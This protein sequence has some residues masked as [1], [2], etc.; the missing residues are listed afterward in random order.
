MRV[1]TSATLIT[2]GLLIAGCSSSTPTQPSQ[3]TSAQALSDASNAQPPE[4]GKPEIDPTW[5]NGTTVYMI[6]PHVIQGARES[7]PNLYAQ[8]EELYLVV[9]P[10]PEP[11]DSI[12]QP[13]RYQPQCNP[14][15]HPGLPAAFVF[16]DHIITGAPGFGNHG[17]AG[18]Y[19]APWKIII[20]MYN[21][22]YAKSHGFTP[23]TSAEALDNA[24]DGTSNVLV[25]FNH[26]APN[27]YEFETGNVLIC[28][29]I[30]NHG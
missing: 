24:E 28:P 13:P 17:T 12:I 8:A 15:F 1:V 19:K 23:L 6:G 29:T 30:S 7:N 21:P 18:V 5:A 26:G 22:T 4:T 11:G 10:P 2:A 20:A 27:P 14:C 16:H 9:V 3:M 25:P